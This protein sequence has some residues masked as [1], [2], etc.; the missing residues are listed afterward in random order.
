MVS[1]LHVAL[2]QGSGTPT[3][4]TGGLGTALSYPTFGVWVCVA[5]HECGAGERKI[6]CFVYYKVAQAFIHGPVPS[7]CLVCHASAARVANG[8][9]AATAASSLDT[10]FH[11]CYVSTCTTLSSQPRIHVERVL[12]RL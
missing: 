8:T 7:R 4:W 11:Q 6:F 1:V 5:D 10:G 12:H 3:A 2:R 9:A